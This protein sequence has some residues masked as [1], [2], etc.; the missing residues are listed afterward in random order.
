VSKTEIQEVTATRKKISQKWLIL[1]FS[2]AANAEV[3]R[4]KRAGKKVD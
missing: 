3:K 2:N 1:N 4:M